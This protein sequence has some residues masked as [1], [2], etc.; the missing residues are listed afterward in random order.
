MGT[1]YENILSLCEEKGIKAGKMCNDLKLSRSLMSDLKA[2]RKNGITDKTAVKIAD[3]FH[4]SI[5]RVIGGAEKE[6][7]P[8]EDGERT[9]TE[10]DIKAAFWGGEDDLPEDA[11]AELWE[12]AKSYIAFKTEQAKKRRK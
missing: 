1:I 9:V 8:A 4:V 6:K 5:D 3:Y 2:G 11:I 10:E 12:D 7:A